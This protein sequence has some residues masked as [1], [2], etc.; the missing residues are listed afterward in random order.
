MNYKE[1]VGQVHAR[2]KMASLDEAVKAIRAT[3]HTLAERIS[4]GEAEHLAAQLPEEIGAYLKMADGT[5]SFDL[6]TFFTRVAAREPIDLPDAAYH[7]RVVMEVLEEAV[8]PGEMADVRA[9]LP[10]TYA[11]IFE[12]SEGEMSTD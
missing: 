11:P 5:E 12:G 9:Q 7:V 6:D 1:F 2:A 8:T 4:D 10:A 3:L